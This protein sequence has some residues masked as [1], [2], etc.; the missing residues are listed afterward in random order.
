MLARHTQAAS[1]VLHFDRKMS[2]HLQPQPFPERSH[3]FQSLQRRRGGC[4]D[5]L[6]LT[7]SRGSA[8]TVWLLSWAGSAQGRPDSMARRPTDVQSIQ[9]T[10]PLRK[11]VWGL[12]GQPEAQ[13]ALLSLVSR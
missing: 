4:P 2:S 9:T 5:P 12:Q 11:C 7:T 1:G 10:K 13:P 8:R 6:V 3:L